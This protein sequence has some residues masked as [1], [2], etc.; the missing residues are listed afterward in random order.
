M[1]RNPG[2]S[3]VRDYLAF[4]LEIEKV[5]P[6]NVYDLKAYRP[7]GISCAATLDEQGGL[8]LWHGQTPQGGIAD[9]FNREE[10]IQLVRYLEHQVETGKTILTWNGVG[11]DF[12]ILA[13]E[14]GLVESCRELALEHVDMMFHVFCLQGYALGLDKAAKGMGLPGKTAGMSGVMAPVYWAQGRRDEVLAYLEQDVRTTLRLGQE[15]ERKRRLQWI[16]GRGMQ[17]SLELPGGWLVAREA[18]QLPTPDTSWMSR[19][20]PRSKF[21]GWLESDF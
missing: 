5:L 2:A 17:Q 20:W 12:D 1:D 15:V 7:L 10:A 4:D 11:F 18:L 13:E 8:I 14:S 3:T 21:T 9:R 6:E 16:S 19:P